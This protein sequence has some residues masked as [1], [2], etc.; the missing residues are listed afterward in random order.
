MNRRKFLQSVPLFAPVPFI[1]KNASKVF[2]SKIVDSIVFDRVLTPEKRV[3][4]N[5]GFIYHYT[6]SSMPQIATGQPVYQLQ[7][8]GDYPSI[9][10][11]E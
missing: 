2:E 10:R 1:S 7:N 9:I 4:I 8:F 6:A 11:N 5:S 3:A